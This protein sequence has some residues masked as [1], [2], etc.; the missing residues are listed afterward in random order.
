MLSSLDRA[1]HLID[2]TYCKEV[3]LAHTPEP[4]PRVF[5]EALASKNVVVTL[6]EKMSRDIQTGTAVAYMPA[7]IQTKTKLEEL[8]LGLADPLLTS[9]DFFL[10]LVGQMAR[11]HVL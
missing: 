8:S 10:I 1:N 11:F 4:T 6:E 2:A 5:L 9:F 7:P 3:R